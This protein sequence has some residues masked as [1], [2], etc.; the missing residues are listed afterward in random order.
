M[1]WLIFALVLIIFP[2]AVVKY[3]LENIGVALILFAF[4][5]VTGILEALFSD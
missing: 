5:A 4:I 1:E 3:L 2:F